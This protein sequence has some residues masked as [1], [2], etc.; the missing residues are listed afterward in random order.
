MG[1][2]M[3]RIIGHRGAAKLWAENSPTGFKRT[4]SLDIEGVEF[5]VHRTLDGELVVIHDP[6]IDRTMNGTGAVCEMTLK[7]LREIGLR[8]ADG[9]TI[10]TLQEVLQIFRQT[11]HELQ[12]E[13]K[14]DAYGKPYPGL[15]DDVMRVASDLGVEERCVLTSFIPAVLEDACNRAVGSRYLLSIN[16]ASAQQFGGLYPLMDRLVPMTDC[17][18]AIQKDLLQLGLEACV[19]LVGTER[20]G[21]WAPYSHS[22]LEFWMQQ[23]IGQITTDRPDIA[24]EFRDVKG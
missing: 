15:V 23:P 21:V 6:K 14:V 2:K 10:P 18:F 5:D 12:I 8:E 7:Q 16:L 11:K 9:D 22:E 13:I 19:D 24:A 1:D 3:V 20:L 4:S 17:I